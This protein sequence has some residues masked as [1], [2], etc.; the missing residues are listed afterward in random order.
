M[1][2]LEL[3]FKHPSTVLLSGPT[4]CR[5]TRFVRRIL[6]ERLI[7]T[8]PTRL[9]WVYSEWQ[10]DYDKIT[11]I[12]P[13]IE[14]MK[15]YSDDIYDSLEPS[16]RNLLILED[17]LS[18]ASSTKSLANRFTKGSHHRNVTILY[19]VQN[20][21]DKGRSS[22]TVS[23]NS[24]Y[25]V[26]FR[27]LRDQ[28]QFR[29]M[30]RKILPKNSDCLIDAYADATVRPFGYIVIDNSL[31]CD[32]IFRF[33]T[34]IFRGELPRVYCDKKAVYKSPRLSSPS[35]IFFQSDKQIKIKQSS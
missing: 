3:H 19:L 22:R 21:F 7:D 35:K 33:R 27:N 32:P 14:F 10:E 8:F 23:L 12:Y 1:T 29:T 9:I 26:V 4:G 11:T 25:T 28:S 31:Q 15:G 20:M 24:H 18:E 16:D 34:N 6:E 13:E 17:Q 5:K 30:A 2:N